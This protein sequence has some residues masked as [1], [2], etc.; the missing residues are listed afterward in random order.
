MKRLDKTLRM[1]RVSAHRNMA[2]AAD[3]L[4]H[5]CEDLYERHVESH[6][7]RHGDIFIMYIYIYIYICK[8]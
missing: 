3:E 7:E 4:N 5:L 2:R 8:I 6:D 1:R